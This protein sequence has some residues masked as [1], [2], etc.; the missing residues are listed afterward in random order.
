MLENIGHFGHTTVILVKK[1]QLSL[2]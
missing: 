1:G 2:K